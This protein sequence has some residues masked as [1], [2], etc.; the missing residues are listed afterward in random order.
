MNDIL[1]YI[2]LIFIVTC[3]LC[4]AFF[5]KATGNS[6]TVLIIILAWFALQG[7]ISSTGF[8]MQSQTL[9]PRFLLLVA[10][11]FI[12]ILVFFFTKKGKRFID[13]LNTEYLTYLH[14]VRL[15]V[16][17]VLFLLFLHKQIPQLMTFEGRNFDILSG[18]SAPIVAYLFFKRRKISAKLMIVWN[19]IC[20]LLVFN[21]MTYGV[22]SV[23]GPMQQ[24]GFDQPNIG[25]LKFPFVWL[26]GFIVPVVIFSHLVSLR[27]LFRNN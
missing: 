20:L 10:P 4:I 27:S 6:K 9:P 19:I 23:P 14:S 25:V 2:S 8:Y 1:F 24:F 18:I 13:S 16:E 7:F 15:P 3:I 22:L 12:S 11:P 21:I 26:P 17:I 5:Y